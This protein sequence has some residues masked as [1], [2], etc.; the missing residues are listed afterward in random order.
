MRP[1]EW[2]PHYS[3]N[4]RRCQ[5]ANDKKSYRHGSF[6]KKSEM[7]RLGWTFRSSNFIRHEIPGSHSQKFKPLALEK[8]QQAL[9]YQCSDRI[10]VRQTVIKVDSIHQLAVTVELPSK[11][12]RQ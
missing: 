3:K 4:G 5:I 12:G 7:G 8:Y 9:S 6:S 1:K 11:G 2:G 10:D